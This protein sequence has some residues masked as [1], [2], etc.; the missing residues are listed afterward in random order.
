MTMDTGRTDDIRKAVASGEWQAALHHWEFYVAG[1]RAEI[2]RGACTPA[3][4]AEARKFLDWARRVA[5]CARAQAQN[6][7]NTIHAARQYGS[8]S[9]P[10]SSLRTIL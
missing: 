1:I 3:R 7:L 8:P 6:R 4:M 5:L 9:R 10:P 2:R